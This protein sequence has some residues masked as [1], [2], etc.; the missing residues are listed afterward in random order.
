MQCPQC[1]FENPDGAKFCNECGSRIEVCCPQCQTKNSPGSKFCSECG[2]NLTQSTSSSEVDF[3]QPQSYT[4]K[5]LAEK[6]LTSRTS[7]EGE[8]KIVTVMF[9]DVADFTSLSEKLDPE[10]VHQIMDGCFKIL[11]DEIHRYE[12][13]INQFTGDGVMALFGAPVAHED[14]AQRACHSA[15]HIQKAIMEFGD[16]VSRDYGQNFKIR[17]GLNSGPVIVGAIGDDLRMD[18]TAVGDTTNLAARME[19]LAR[20][21]S[22]LVS[23]SI[24]RRVKDF[25]DLNPLGQVSVKG[26]EEPQKAFELLKT[27]EAL[28]RLDAARARGLTRFI[29]RE[30][31]MAAIKEAYAKVK[32]GSGQIL[33][34]A[35]EAGVGKSRLVAEFRDRLSQEEFLYLEG[36][37]I[38]YGSAMPYLPI[39]DI[40]RSYFCIV[41]G[42]REIPIRK[43]VTQKVLGLDQNLPET[44]PPLQD[45]LS[46]TIEDEAYSQLEPKQKKDLIFEALR[47]LFLSL[48]QNTPLVL[49][50]EDLHWIDSTTEAF[51]D[52]LIGWMAT[53][54]IM[55]VLIYRLEYTH[56]WGNKSYFTRSA[57]TSWM[58]SRVANSWRRSLKGDRRRLNSERPF[59]SGQQAIPCSWRNSPIPFWKTVSFKKK[60]IGMS[61]PAR[62]QAFRYRIP[63][64]GSSPPAS[65]GSRNP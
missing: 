58:C 46:L 2:K 53:A 31:A 12:G 35:G 44:I 24:F 62:H 10:E 15:L 3:A 43:R 38:H 37:C 7:L 45:L 55:L 1:Q 18:Y 5:H 6:I 61:F 64:R 54:R 17:I 16:K 21:G 26:K 59:S 8:R 27:G 60:T 13:A 63:S 50:I 32:N 33:G 29:G 48:A 23:E 20:S 36:R 40:L 56:Q 51:L 28:S 19:H 65:T 47:N 49:V 14:H 11:M 4:P 22:V 41:E 42:E 57:S 9:A 52:Y 30:N 34:V 39:L 25:F